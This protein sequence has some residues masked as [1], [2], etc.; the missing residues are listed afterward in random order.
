[1][2]ARPAEAAVGHR[3]LY[4]GRPLDGP[5]RRRPPPGNALMGPPPHA[6]WALSPL[7]EPPGLSYTMVSVIRTWRTGPAVTSTGAP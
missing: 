7:K 3:L 4:R 1:M 5:P 6:G 2:R